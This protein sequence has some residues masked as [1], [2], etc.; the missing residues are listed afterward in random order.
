MAERVDFWFDPVCP[1]AFATSRWIREVEKV[2]DVETHWNVMSLGVLNEE[3]NPS[4][5]EDEDVLARWIP[6]RTATAV[7]QTAPEKVGE[8]YNAI[9]TEIHIHGHRDFEAVARRAVTEIGLDESLVEDAK[10]DKH[11]EVMRASH[12]EA[13]DR[14]GQDVG[15]PVVAFADTAFFGPVITRIPEGEEAG[16]LFDA[17][18]ALAEYPYFF[19]LKRSRSESP[20]FG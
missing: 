18:V 14:V 11:D 16:K 10:T 3:K 1:F 15:T 9:G 12:N 6:A 20:Q 13:I 2:R 5:D 7:S 8:F 17:S 19:E 4:P